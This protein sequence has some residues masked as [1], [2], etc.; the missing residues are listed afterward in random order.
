VAFC[1]FLSW[2]K[3]KRSLCDKNKGLDLQN[4]Q[5]FFVFLL[6]EEMGELPPIVGLIS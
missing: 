1:Y 6:F 5:T 2:K 3:Q 4:E